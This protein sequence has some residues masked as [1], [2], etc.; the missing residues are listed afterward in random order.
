MRSDWVGCGWGVLAYIA[1]LFG[2]INAVV[3]FLVVT[4]MFAKVEE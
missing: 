2:G 4:L 3:I 1:Y